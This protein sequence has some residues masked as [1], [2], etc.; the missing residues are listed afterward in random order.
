V[1]KKST[2]PQRRKM[3]YYAQLFKRAN[4]RLSEARKKHTREVAWLEAALNRANKKLALAT[5]QYNEAQEKF[6]G[7][8]TWT[9]PHE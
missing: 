2:A 6:N 5:E 8:V 9:P 4:K 3:E 7:P 1:N